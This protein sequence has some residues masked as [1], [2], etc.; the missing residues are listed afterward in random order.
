[1]KTDNIPEK[2]ACEDMEGNMALT[3]GKNRLNG[4][5]C[6]LLLLFLIER[7]CAPF[8]GGGN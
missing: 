7:A 6:L 1:M 4:K 3:A 5:S 2:F 8:N